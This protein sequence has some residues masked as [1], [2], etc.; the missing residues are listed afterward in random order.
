MSVR[1]WAKVQEMLWSFRPLSVLT[2]A[3]RLF[4]VSLLVL[5]V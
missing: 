4:P 1:Q 5:D 2:N 3:P